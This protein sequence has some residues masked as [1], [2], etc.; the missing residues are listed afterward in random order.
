MR[1]T[2]LSILVALSFASL[3]ETL[4]DVFGTVEN[5]F[6]IEF[7]TIADEN[8]P[9]DG[10]AG[11][12]GSMPHAYRIGKYEISRGMIEQANELGGL[13][14]TLQDMLFQENGSNGPDQP[15]TGISWREGAK[16]VNWL[17]TSSGSQPAYKFR[18]ES[19]DHWRPGEAGY[20]A[21][22]PLRNDKAIYFLPSADEWHKSAFYDPIRQ[23]YFDFPT[24]SD[25]PPAA[26]EQGTDAN[27]AVYGGC[28]IWCE[29]PTSPR[30]SGPAP[31]DQ[32]GGLSLYGTMAQGG[33][34]AEWQ[35][36]EADLNNDDP[37]GDRGIR[38]GFWA[39]V[40]AESFSANAWDMGGVPPNVD[41]PSFGFRVASKIVIRGDFN[42][43]GSLDID[44]IEVLVDA[45]RSNEDWARFDLS[46][47]GLVSPR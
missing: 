44:D 33:N 9:D 26:V 1:I 40:S 16:F 7:V 32:A 25:I 43:D 27:T 29:H 42:F 37:S 15:A 46:G 13:M 12:I 6:P 21:T 47:D 4:A 36:T 11:F 28:F 31:I 41:Y 17:N 30:P 35:E 39:A 24:G 20:D 23:A 5:E 38:G 34:V 19:L 45:I 22:N 8:N 18:G 14:I 3:H 10:S 2:P